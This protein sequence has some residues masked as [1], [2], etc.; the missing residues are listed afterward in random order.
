MAGSNTAQGL[1]NDQLNFKWTQTSGTPAI[2]LTNPNTPTAG[3]T[4]PR[5]TT[6]TP[7]TFELTVSLKSDATKTSKATV[8][9]K[10]SPTAPDIVT[11]DTYTWESRQSGTISVSCSSNVRNGDNKKMTLLVN[12]VSNIPMAVSGG[13]G[14]WAYTARSTQRPNTVQCVSDLTGKSAQRTG[15]QTTRRKRRGVLGAL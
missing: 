1:T 13:A 12:G 6:E 15:T 11:I 4:A 14:R 10:I 8:T 7:F 3:F 5:V 2:T 9:V